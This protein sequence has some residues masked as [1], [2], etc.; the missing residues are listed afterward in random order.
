MN[1]LHGY[2]GRVE[3]NG[4]AYPFANYSLSFVERVE[5]PRRANKGREWRLF[6]E[7]LASIS[8]RPLL[9]GECTLRAKWVKFN[10][11]LFDKLLY[12]RTAL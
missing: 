9:V 5:R 12:E 11:E 2:G 4:R 10:Q 3:I 8:E 7:T 1:K 6:Y